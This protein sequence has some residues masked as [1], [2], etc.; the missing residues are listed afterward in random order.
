MKNRLTILSMALFYFHANGQ[1]I[2]DPSKKRTANQFTDRI[3]ITE[4]I[5]NYSR[6]EERLETEKQVN[7]FA[8][9]TI[10]EI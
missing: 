8:D 7:V 10:I 1:R 4:L 9:Y 6:F 3:A 5:N 2:G